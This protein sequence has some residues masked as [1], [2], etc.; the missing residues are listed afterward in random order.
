MLRILCEGAEDKHTLVIRKSR[1]KCV[2]S[3]V[4]QGFEIK[5][6]EGG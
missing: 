2:F 4:H 3:F 6:I 1:A 5:N